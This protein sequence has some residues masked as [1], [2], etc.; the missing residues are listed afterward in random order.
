MQYML[1]ILHYKTTS[2]SL[3]TQLAQLRYH[4]KTAAYMYLCVVGHGSGPST[5]RVRS[6]PDLF[7]TQLVGS[8]GVQL[9]GSAWVTL[10]DPEF[11]AKS[12]CKVCI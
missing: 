10:D 2:Y 5:D 4:Q 9:C 8:V 7:L 12:N 6:D 3:F 11:Y 1:S